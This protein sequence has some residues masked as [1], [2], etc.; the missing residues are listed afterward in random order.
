M[1][2]NGYRDI[3]FTII[4]S[5]ICF[6]RRT[7]PLNRVPSLPVAAPPCPVNCHRL[8]NGLTLIHHDLPA[9]DV[10]AVDVWVKAGAIVEP[11]DWMGMA[12]FLEHMIFKGTEQLPPGMFDA[13]I[14]QF[15]GSTNAATGHDYAHYFITTAAPHLA[16]TLPY[17][18]EILVNA[19]IPDDEFD[20]ERD[21]VL[22][23]IRQ[24]ADNPDWVAFQ[25]LSELAYQRHAY[26]RQI[27]GTEEILMARSPAEMRQFHRTHYQPANI[28]VVIV[29]NVTEARALDLVTE[30]F[31]Q[32]LPPGDAPHHKSDAEPPIPTIR[33][34]EL[35]L[36]RLEQARLMLAWHGPGVDS[37]LQSVDQQVQAAYGLDV[38][39][40]VLAEGRTSRLVKE[41]REE[42]QLVQGVSSGFALQKEAGLFTISA[43]LE[44]EHLERVEAIICDRLAELLAKPITAAELA[45]CQR[46]LCNDHA[47]STETPCQ[48]AGLY[49]YYSILARPDI[50]LTYP[51]RIQA[52]QPDYLQTL[53][54]QYLSPCHYAATIVRPL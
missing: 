51:S 54:Q 48:L 19:A 18:A 13:A 53:A 6:V 28:T 17:L 2:S 14:E 3:K 34:Q 31:T 37:P 8:A 9:T 46:L 44:P 30:H 26:G 25:A 35:G 43:W 21:V 4:F 45:R 11:D 41:L 5:I 36:P 52:L 23:E 22:E 12:H 16:A 7:I 39:S 42:R 27:L 33:R 20:R 32:F 40:I 15:G 1:L 38:L 49:G 10:V 24:A 47:F 50:A 29:G